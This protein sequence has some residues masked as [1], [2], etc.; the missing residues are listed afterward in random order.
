VRPRHD[1]FGDSLLQQRW[2]YLR[3]SAVVAEIGDRFDRQL[4]QAR[5]AVGFSVDKFGPATT[6][7]SEAEQG[8]FS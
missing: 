1:G 2:I 7:V 6:G 5:P 3:L 4:S 8:D